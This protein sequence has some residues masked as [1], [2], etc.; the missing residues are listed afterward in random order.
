MDQ[1][2]Q[3]SISRRSIARTIGALLIVLH[4]L[5]PGLPLAGGAPA[6]HDATPGGWLAVM[7]PQKGTVTRAQPRAVAR[8]A[9]LSKAER[10][11]RPA[12]GVALAAS[13]AIGLPPLPAI[14]A[15]APIRSDAAPAAKSNHD[16]DARGPPRL[17][18]TMMLP[19]PA[20]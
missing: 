14:A 19:L 10:H 18:T 7:E 8:D 17:L 5:A 2:L 3:G 20:A 15:L 13:A 11:K 1:N 4:W 16:Y 9:G 6:W 12:G